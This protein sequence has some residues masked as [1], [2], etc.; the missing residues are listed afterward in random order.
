MLHAAEAHRKQA[1]ESPEHSTEPF[2]S[3]AVTPPRPSRTDT[4]PGVAPQKPTQP[5]D[6]SDQFH[7]E[8]F[9]SP[10]ED[11]PKKKPKR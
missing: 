2:E 7:T 6:D 9:T 5:E 4:D 10:F 1:E 3:L 11:E 8:A